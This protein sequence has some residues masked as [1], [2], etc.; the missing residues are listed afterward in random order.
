MKSANGQAEGPNGRTAMRFLWIED[1]YG[2]MWQ[3]RDGDNIKK[4]Q[5]YFCMNRSSYADNVYDGDYFKLG[6]V[7]PSEN[8]YPKK[9]ELT[10]ST[11]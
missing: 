11:R 8:G 7:C 9:W 1:W 5:H 4:W 2:N 6:Y 3:F 10:N